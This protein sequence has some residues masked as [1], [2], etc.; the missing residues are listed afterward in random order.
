M[1]VRSYHSLTCDE[2]T[3][4]RG[5]ECKI[6]LPDPRVAMHHAVIKRLEDGQPHL[7]AI[8]GELESDGAQQQNIALTNGKQVLI[9][10]YQLTVEPAPPDVDVAVSLVLAHRLPDDYQDLKSRT[11]EPLPGA[12]TFK[13]RLSLLMAGLIALIFLMLP[14]AQVLIP[15]LRA[16]I[17]DWPIGFDRVWSPGRVSTSHQHFSSQCENCHEGPTQRVSD[18]ACVSCHRDTAP[19]IVDPA[20]Q[21]RVF[22]GKGFFS[23]RMRCAEC[24]REHKAPAPLVR[25]DSA[26]CVKCHD[27]IKAVDPKTPLSD[28]HDFDRDHLDFKLTFKTGPAETDIERIPQTETARLVEKSGLKFPHNQH[29]GL[30][31]G[32]GG[33]SDIRDL[34]CASCHRP[35]GK[36]MRFKPLS[37]KRDCFACH[38]DRLEVGPADARLRLPHAAEQDVLNA[39]KVNAPKQVA[40]YLDALKTDGC[41]YCHE[42]AATEK[43]DTLPWRVMPLRITQDWFSKA[44]FNHA[45]HRTQQCQSCHQVEHSESSSDVAIPDR[46]SCLKCHAGNSPKHRRIT[47][48][49]MSC[50]DFHNAHAAQSEARRLHAPPK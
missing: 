41:A 30:V 33:M 42:M 20:L 38:A 35:E 23:G 34:A 17:A 25:Q 43:G 49:C 44:R 24:H 45:S 3:L 50:H 21:Q 31:Q 14:L 8:H 28:I 37:F 29:I 26:T 1:P 11:H 5:A 6:H 4:G 10:P 9:G 15:Q 18:K 27:D 47:S 12:S 16:S 7:V 19:H 13:R 2:V 22:Q 39:L 36:E 40:R 46:T 48:S 32:P